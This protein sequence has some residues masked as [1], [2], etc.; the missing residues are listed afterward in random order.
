MTGRGY[1]VGGGFTNKGGEAMTLTLVRALHERFPNVVPLVRVQASE[2]NVAKAHGVAP[3]I[4]TPSLTL[5][6]RVQSKWSS[7][8]AALSYDAMLDVGGYQFGDS[9][10]AGIPRDRVRLMRALRMLG[11]PT[12]FLPQAWGPFTDEAVATSVKEVLR[13]AELA[14]VRDETSMRAVERLVGGSHRAVHFAHDIAWNFQGESSERGET[15]LLEA[16]QG[17]RPQRVMCLTPNLR[18]FERSSGQGESNTYLIALLRAAHRA[19][20]AG[21]ATLLLGHELRQAADPRP[22]DRS[23]CRHLISRLNPDVIAGHIDSALSAA[24]VKALIGRCDL[25]IGSRYHAVIAA[26]SQGVPP[27]V[28]GWSHKYDELLK[29]IGMP[30]RVLPVDRDDGAIDDAVDSFILD[31]PSIRE[32]LSTRIPPLRSSAREAVARVMSAMENR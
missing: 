9:W 29:V 7:A 15:L 27:L 1:I 4:A 25:L 31:A 12:F 6:Q 20:R 10:G 26:A 14:F 30:G 22:D 5:A 13:N 11:K 8:L 3:V 28:A 17:S 19:S 23:L 16:F 2:T 32:T 21:F 18:V 24:D